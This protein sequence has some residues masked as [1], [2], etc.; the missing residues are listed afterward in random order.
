MCLSRLSVRPPSTAE[1]STEARGVTATLTPLLWLSWSNVSL[2]K[3]TNAETQGPPRYYVAFNM[4]LVGSKAQILNMQMSLSGV[5]QWAE[6]G[7]VT[8]KDHPRQI[9]AGMCGYCYNNLCDYSF[10]RCSNDQINKCTKQ[11]VQISSRISAV[12]RFCRGLSWGLTHIWIWWH[13]L[14]RDVS[15]SR[16]LN[17]FIPKCHISASGG[18]CY[19]IFIDQ[20]FQHVAVCIPWNVTF[21]KAKSSWSHITSLSFHSKTFHASTVFTH[22][23][24]WWQMS[25]FVRKTS[26][27][28]LKLVMHCK[29]YVVW[30]KK[31]KHYSN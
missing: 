9:S 11:K 3:K 22:S 19:L 15:N 20:Y 21:I 28:S 7:I 24:F 8:V 25:L 14:D 6:W 30:T 29:W 27:H 1:D 17:Y 18:K 5:W 16:G 4:F 23:P 13:S 10:H 31:T 2:L 26:N 12:T